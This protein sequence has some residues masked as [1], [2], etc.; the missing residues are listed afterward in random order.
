MCMQCIGAAGLG[1][2]ARGM[3]RKLRQVAER[4]FN[5]VAG[6]VDDA[7]GIRLLGIR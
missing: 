2:A 5:L 7:L 4:F 3:I 1:T 6:V